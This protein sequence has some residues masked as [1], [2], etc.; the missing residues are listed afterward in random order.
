MTATKA[1]RTVSPVSDAAASTP[2]ADLV[3]LE[4]RGE[5]W[6]LRMHHDENRFNRASV[7]ALHAALDQVEAV[8]GPRALVTTGDGKFFSNGLDLDWL[9]GGGEDSVGFLDDVHRLFGRIL[10]F[11]AYTVAAVNGHAFAGGAMLATAHD[12]VVMRED[13]GYWC[14]PEVDLGLPLTPAMYATVAAHLPPPTLADAALTGRRYS[15]PEALAAGI[16]HELAPQDAVVER[17]VAIAAALAGK[18]RTVIAEHKRLMYGD[19]IAVC[20]GSA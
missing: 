10:G 15:G 12:H 19:A 2:F 9:L 6:V 5:V 8:E 1:I 11:P 13:R 7:D 3:D 4:P 16:A 17:A 14:L 20:T 18:D